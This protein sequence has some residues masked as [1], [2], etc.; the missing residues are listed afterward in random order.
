MY[1]IFLTLH[2]ILRWVVVIAGLVTVIRALAGWLG[3]R[4]F[5][6]ADN[7]AGALYTI[8]LDIQI[9][10]GLLLYFAFSPLTRMIF[11][12]LDQVMQSDTARFFALEHSL[13]M[14]VAAVLA[15]VGRSQ[16][17]REPDRQ[18][19]RAGAMWYVLSLLVLL[20][21]IPWPFLEPG[22]PWLRLLG[23]VF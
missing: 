3:N 16:R 21:S 13:A 1:P 6:R 14:V 9:L 15:H 5:T 7:S 2:N 4:P 8:S 12:G 18:K 20:A 11:E 10:V 22:R 19:H 23:L 17:K